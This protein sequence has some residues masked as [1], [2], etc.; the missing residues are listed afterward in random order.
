M[1]AIAHNRFQLI[2]SDAAKPENDRNGALSCDVLTTAE[3]QE[4]WEYARSNEMLDRLVQCLQ[5]TTTK[6]VQKWNDDSL[7]CS[8]KTA[9]LNYLVQSGAILVKELMQQS[10]LETLK[11]CDGGS[12]ASSE[13]A[14]ESDETQAMEQD[15]P[16]M[17]PEEDSSSCPEEFETEQGESD[18]QGNYQ[19]TSQEE[20]DSYAEKEGEDSADALHYED[21]AKSDDVNSDESPHR[22]RFVYNWT[23]TENDS[24]SAEEETL[25]CVVKGAG[26][27]ETACESGGSGQE[28]GS[29]GASVNSGNQ[30]DKINAGNVVLGENAGDSTAEGGLT[31]AVSESST[32]SD[33]SDAK[34]GENQGDASPFRMMQD[35]IDTKLPNPTSGTLPGSS[36]LSQLGQDLNNLSSNIVVPSLKV[37]QSIVGGVA[38]NAQNFLSPAQPKLTPVMLG[39]QLVFLSSPPILNNQSNIAVNNEAARTK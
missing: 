10:N 28:A 4:L 38:S 3:S 21:D 31:V 16:G 9:I 20:P 14:D 11:Q 35:L 1:S 24:D 12:I 6:L 37:Q 32:L 23:I 26:D 15:D 33:K 5:Q 22:R 17:T 30:N 27:I 39:N 18:V 34:N 29:C 8:D 36:G 7:T 13:N 19:V 25:D 2:F